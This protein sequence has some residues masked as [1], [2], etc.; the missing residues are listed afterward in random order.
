MRVTSNPV[1]AACLG[2][3]LVVMSGLA[4]R[5][6]DRLVFCYDPYPPYAHIGDDGV[7]LGLKVQLLHA[8][9]A[10]IDGVTAEVVLMPWKRCQEEARKGHVDGILPLFRNA[11]RATY[12]AFSDPTYRETSVFWYRTDNADA[13]ANWAGDYDEIAHLHLAMLNGGHINTEMQDAFSNVRPIVRTETAE[14][15]FLMLIHRRVD[16]VALDLQVGRFYARKF[17]WVDTV[18]ALDPPISS[19]V[20]VFGL[21]RTSGADRYLPAF[22]RTLA[23]MAA[24]GE[25]AEIFDAMA[26]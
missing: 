6:D 3:C 4:A 24:A 2:L 11:E 22:N 18:A 15:L 21:S 26:D 8:V 23:D 17:G 1:W 12:L 10:R 19:Q 16:L 5:A 9:M 7:A 25:V 13:V 14:A 20:S